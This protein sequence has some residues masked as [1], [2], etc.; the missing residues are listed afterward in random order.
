MARQTGFNR[1][2]P[3]QNEEIDGIRTKK[4]RVPPK[5]VESSGGIF[6]ASASPGRAAR[7]AL[8]VSGSVVVN[9]STGK[10]MLKTL[11]VCLGI[12]QA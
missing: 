9:T 12:K 10:A 8:L 2:F 6:D 11:K 3:S 4:T 7:I 1:I 5:Q